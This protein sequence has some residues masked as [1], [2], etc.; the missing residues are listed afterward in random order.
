MDT[1]ISGWKHLGRQHQREERQRLAERERAHHR[2]SPGL[3]LAHECDDVTR[4]GGHIHGAR[5][6]EALVEPGSR[7]DPRR[8]A[9]GAGK[10][11][12]F[13]RQWRMAYHQ[14]HDQERNREGGTSPHSSCACHHLGPS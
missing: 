5:S 11:G 12:L 14:R 7:S 6:S 1:A 8:R 4:V 2:G 3:V 13:L 10:H 9:C